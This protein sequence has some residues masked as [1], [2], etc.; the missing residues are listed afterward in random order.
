M[1]ASRR[2]VTYQFALAG[3]DAFAGAGYRALYRDHQ[4]G[5]FERDVTMCGPILGAGARFLARDKPDRDLIGNMDKP[6]LEK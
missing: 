6:N 3:Y 1:P 5:G 2:S 4:D